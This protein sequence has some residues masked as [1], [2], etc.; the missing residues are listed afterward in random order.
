MAFGLTADWDAVPDIE[1]LA[2]GI[3]HGV[4]GLEAAAKARRSR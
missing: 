1:V 4:D 2:R 3:E